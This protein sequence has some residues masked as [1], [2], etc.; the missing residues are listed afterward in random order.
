M[1]IDTSDTIEW[2][3]FKE[4]SAFAPMLLHGISTRKGGVSAS[5]YQ[6]LNVGLHV[7]DTPELVVL[8]RQLIA[9]HL[10]IASHQMFFLKQI[11][12]GKIIALDQ[13]P[14]DKLEDK[15]FWNEKNVWAEADAWTTQLRNVALVVQM[16]D[17]A[18]VLLYDSEKKAI[19]IAHAGWRG[20]VAEIVKNTLQ[21]MKEKYQTNPQNVWAGISPCI[22][23]AKYEV[24]DEVVN[25]VKELF[26]MEKDNYLWWNENT[27][28]YHFDLK[29]ANESQLL[30]MGVPKTQISISEHCTLTENHLFF[31]ARRDG[32]ASGRILALMMLK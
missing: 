31:S 29:K 17:C 19:G 23:V 20:T 28:K 2:L 10:G 1:Q 14:T 25:T 5:P 3:Q 32:N 13:L 27:Q 9:Q 21:Q 26:P 16:A 11:H 15:G 22:S 18:A 4:L 24:G 30:A 6:S 8:N 12:S 7:S